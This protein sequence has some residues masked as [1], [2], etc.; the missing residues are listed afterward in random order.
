MLHIV[1]GLSTQGTL[2][3]TD[4]RGARIAADDIFAEGPVQDCLKTS[5]AWRTRAEYLQ[6]HFAIPKEQ[7]LQRKEERERSLRSFAYHEEVVLWFEFD[8]FCQLNLLYLLHWFSDKELGHSRLT[9]ICPGEFP[10]LKSFRGLGAL[11]PRQLTNLFEDRAEVTDEQRKVA[12]K[13]WSAYSSP[14]PTQIQVLLEQGTDELPQL[15]KALSA[16]LERFPWTGHGLN[17]VE[18][19]VLESLLDGPRKF[20]DLFGDVGNSEK[21]FSHGMGDVQFSAY[22]AELAEGEDALIR[23]DNFPGILTQE[24][25]PRVLGK[26]TIRISDRGKEVLKGRQDNIELR[27]IDRWLGGVHLKS[28]EQVW[29][30]DPSTG[31]LV[32]PAGV[33]GQKQGAEGVSLS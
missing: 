13:A 3:R 32:P 29:R 18:V 7:Y 6:K 28:P 10:G 31:R 15:H 20:S 8:L 30:W 2:D 26:W 33:G 25:P 27:G 17:S 14:D 23:M 22:L 5:A 1:N 11:S 19:K 9:L 4:I 16:H 24:V 21:V 12:A